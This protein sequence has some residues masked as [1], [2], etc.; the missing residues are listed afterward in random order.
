MRVEIRKTIVLGRPF[1]QGL[2]RLNAQ[3]NSMILIL[4]VR[5]AVTNREVTCVLGWGCWKRRH[6]ERNSVARIVFVR[7][8]RK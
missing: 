7:F 5:N 6:R 8:V 3:H 2:Q 1:P 4:A